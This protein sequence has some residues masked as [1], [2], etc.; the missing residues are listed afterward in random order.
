[1]HLM[2]GPGNKIFSLRNSYEIPS[3]DDDDFF[4]L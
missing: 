3:G 4:L 1:M 2:F